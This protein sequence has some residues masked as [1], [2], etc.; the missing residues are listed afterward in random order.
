MNILF[1][2]GFDEKWER[3]YEDL[4]KEFPQVSFSNVTDQEKRAEALKKCDAVVTG[5][6]SEQEIKNAKKLKVIFV[7]FTGL[8]NFPLEI[9]KSKK[10]I[11]SNTHANAPYVAERAV[12]LAL[13]LLGRVV[14]FHND[15]AK[16]MWSR[17]HDND[18]LWQSIRG[19]TCG[20]LGLG[21]IG[22]NIAKYLKPYDCRIIGLK[23]N[24]HEITKGF[25]GE[26]SS[27]LNYVLDKSE[28]IF[29]ALPLN[30]E[31]KHILNAQNLPKLKGKYIINVGRGETIHEEA[32]YNALKDGTLAGA[33]LDVWYNYPGK[34][35]EPV[36][37]A[38]FQFWEMKNVV[39]SPHKAS[40]TINAV[41]AM[42][43]DTVE[44]IRTYIFNGVPKEAVKI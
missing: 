12:T 23:R 2:F 9:I 43:D 30:P 10:I 31:T 19:R 25:D 40:S 35:T 16:G 6:L 7:P 42:I 15:L 20:I 27:E 21:H 22:I 5:R 28:I 18:D 38:N 14:E 33:A 1:L 26:V 24:T 34:K 29:A 17:T 3:K 11:I 8:N 4:K 37:P 44:N 13:S 36:F 39:I 41:N 32:L